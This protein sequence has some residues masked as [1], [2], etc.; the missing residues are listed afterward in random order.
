M[1]GAL[2]DVKIGR[3]DVQE[4]RVGDQ[5]F[6]FSHR[7]YQETLFV[8]H[9]ARTENYLPHNELL[10]NSRW[11]EYAVTLLQTQEYANIEPILI[12]ATKLIEGY[13]IKTKINPISDEFGGGLVFYNWVDDPIVPL[14]TILQEGLER[15][16]ND[17]PTYLSSNVER[18][19]SPRWLNGDMYDQLMVLRLGGLLPQ[20]VLSEYIAFAI[21]HGGSTMES[22]AF[23]QSV[24]LKDMPENLGNWVR[25]RLSN[26][27]IKACKQVDILRLEALSGR[28]P[29]SI[30]AK[31]VLNR[32]KLINSIRKPFRMFIQSHL[33][34]TEK[35][36]QPFLPSSSLSVYSRKK[37]IWSLEGALDFT[38]AFYVFIL[39]SSFSITPLIIDLFDNE[40]TSD[41]I[42]KTISSLPIYY[43]I[44]SI[45]WLMFFA[46]EFV[47]L[48]LRAVGEKISISYI[49]RQCCRFSFSRFQARLIFRILIY[50]VIFSS[51][52]I[53]PG[54]VAH[55]AA[56]ILST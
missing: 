35:M 41:S 21:G 6:T 32:C 23:Q 42:S 10:T 43:E 22:V 27:A 29:A 40:I 18:L 39:I 20:A 13:E 48:N 9:L 15:R 36:L 26:E 4:A 44:F 14:L 17:I 31:Y 5:R 19:L 38:I 25:E 45:S 16:L 56:S 53:V 34:A 33:A 7:R 52:L 3:S 30:G 11:R 24:F 12:E 47:L 51:I 46:I 37:A 54:A 2:V 28:L 55:G 49:F 50:I 1:L 8:R